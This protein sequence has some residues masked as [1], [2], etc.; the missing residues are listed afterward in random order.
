MHA[1]YA[2]DITMAVQ[3]FVIGDNL[4]KLMKL[5]LW[6]IGYTI[7]FSMQSLGMMSNWYKS[8]ISYQ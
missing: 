3:Y 7:V 1:S 2:R 6:L 4:S 8:S 5:Y